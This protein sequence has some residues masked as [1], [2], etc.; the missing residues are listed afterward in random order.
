MC[1]PVKPAPAAPKIEAMIAT[2]EVPVKMAADP[3]PRTAT[4]PA[5]INGAASPAD[6]AEI[7]FNN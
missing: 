6:R 4:A 5:P 7:D 1:I 2:P 3:L